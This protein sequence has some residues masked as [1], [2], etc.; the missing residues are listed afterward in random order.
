VLLLMPFT[1]PAA[2][3][4]TFAMQGPDDTPVTEQLLQHCQQV[5]TQ[6]AGSN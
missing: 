2:A 5:L 4:F 1:A 3:L 6:V